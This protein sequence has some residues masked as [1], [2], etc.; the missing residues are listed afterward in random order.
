MPIVKEITGPQMVEG[1]KFIKLNSSLFPAISVSRF[2]HKD[3]S[4][5][6][7]ENRNQ[8]P[9]QEIEAYPKYAVL[10]YGTG[11]AGFTMCETR[12]AG[13]PSFTPAQVL[14]HNDSNSVVNVGITLV[15]GM[16]CLIP[17]GKNTTA[18][19]IVSLN[20]AVSAVTNYA[21]TTITFFA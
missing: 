20:I 2:I 12:S 15:S 17:V 8:P 3:Q 10:T 5:A 4:D 18:N 19:H 14:I 16:S 6:F 9:I 13:N 7:P 1:S 11:M 21:G